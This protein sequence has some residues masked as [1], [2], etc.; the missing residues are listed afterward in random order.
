MVVRYHSFV[1]IFVSGEGKWL[2]KV[3]F[4]SCCSKVVLKFVLLCYIGRRVWPIFLNEGW[5]GYCG[6]R[7]EDRCGMSWNSKELIMG[8]III[9]FQVQHWNTYN[10]KCNVITILCALHLI[11]GAEHHVYMQLGHSCFIFITVLFCRNHK[12][13]E[14][15]VVLLCECFLNRFYLWV[16]YCIYFLMNYLSTFI[17]QQITTSTTT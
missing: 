13:K 17:C 10:V 11:P 5:I 1:L 9:C 15:F 12:S 4:A 2:V 6:P 3:L 7:W 16:I 8:K 14:V